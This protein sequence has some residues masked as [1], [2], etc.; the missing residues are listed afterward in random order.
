[1]SVTSLLCA[2]VNFYRACRRN[3]KNAGQIVAL[4]FMRPACM[5]PVVAPMGNTRFSRVGFW[6]KCHPEREA[7]CQNARFR[8]MPCAGYGA[9]V[10]KKQGSCI[11]LPD[12]FGTGSSPDN[13][14]KPFSGLPFPSFSRPKNIFHELCPFLCGETF[15]AF[16]RLKNHSL[17]I[18][19]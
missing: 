6:A 11:H 5:R 16:K 9:A 14:E 1:M 17:E 15:F 8:P 19:C 18:K 3:V 10:R 7:R 12:G 13:S 2:R 4:C